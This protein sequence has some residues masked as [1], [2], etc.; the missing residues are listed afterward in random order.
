MAGMEP[1]PMI[2]TITKTTKTPHKLVHMGC[3]VLVY[4]ILEG[5]GSTLIN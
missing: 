2:K 3:E 1:E 5:G 4:L